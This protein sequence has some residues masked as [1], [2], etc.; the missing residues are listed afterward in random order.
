MLRRSLVAAAAVIAMTFP[1]AAA[2][3]VVLDSTDITISVPNAALS[4]YA[5]PYANVH[6]D[7][8]SS[9]TADVSFTS[10]INGGY[11][12]MMGDG[13]TADLNVNGSY[14]FGPVT[15]SNSVAGFTPSFKSNTPGNLSS[16][17]IFDLS[18]D[19]NGGFTQAATTMSFT[20][21]DTGAPW[22][23]AAGV[24]TPNNDGFVAGVHAFACNE[25]GC[26]A[27]TPAAVSG[28]AANGDPSPAPIPESE[29]L[30]LLGSALV[31]F[32]MVRRRRIA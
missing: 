25:P 30:A 11:L 14:T 2:N 24:L 28:F 4:G 5:G 32:G 3:A 19:T 31:V 22:S 29:T 27:T 8:T 20:L 12:H 18:L 23:A 16:F 13:G 15:E 17:G 1:V 6:I 10:L 9:T 7:L 26:S 21:T